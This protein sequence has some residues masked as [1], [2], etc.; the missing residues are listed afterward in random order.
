MNESIAE[1]RN[2]LPDAGRTAPETRTAGE[3]GPSCWRPVLWTLWAVGL[4]LIGLSA[5]M[6]V[7]LGLE[8]GD[9]TNAVRVFVDVTGERNLPA[10]WNSG[11]FLVAGALSL[12]V[13]LLRR[14]DGH[15]ELLL[16]TGLAALLAAMSLDELTSIHERLPGVYRR[17]FGENPLENYAWLM[18]GIPIAVAVLVFVAWAIRSL[19]RDTR[20]L[21]GAG[22]LVFFAGAIGMEVLTGALLPTVGIGS[23]PYVVLYHVEETL[24]FLGASLMVV[25]PLAAGV[26]RSHP[27]G[28]LVLS[29][30]PGSRTVKQDGG[31]STLR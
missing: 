2:D 20:R 13:G 6:P 11:L 26:L 17:L 24:E 15:R 25:A 8:P 27:D 9:R 7:V 5:L 29:W 21:F 4:A 14:R 16:W 1:Q 19:P 28:G 10:W 12:G 22:F 30:N 23:L 18:L 31:V 3:V